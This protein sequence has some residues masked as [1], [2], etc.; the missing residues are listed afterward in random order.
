MW[1]N[2]FYIPDVAK[3]ISMVWFRVFVLTSISSELVGTEVCLD[4]SDWILYEWQGSIRD[5]T[6]KNF[7]E[8]TCSTPKCL[9]NKNQYCGRIK[10]APQS[11]LSVSPFCSSRST[12]VGSMVSAHPVSLGLYSL[13]IILFSIPQLLLGPPVLLHPISCSFSLLKEQWWGH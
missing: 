10:V 13:Y 5:D 11:W 4:L 9:H 3:C 2:I 8:N 1:N 7:P 12:L 6:L